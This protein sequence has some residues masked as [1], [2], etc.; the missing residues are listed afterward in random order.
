M[1]AGVFRAFERVFRFHFASRQ[2]LTQP[3]QAIRAIG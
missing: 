2:N 1:I 3:L